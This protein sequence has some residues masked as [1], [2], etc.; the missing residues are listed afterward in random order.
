MDPS[1]S[2][3]EAG[4]SDRYEAPEPDTGATSDQDAADPARH[5]RFHSVDDLSLMRHN[6][7]RDDTA[8]SL[9]VGARYP[10]GDALRARYTSKDAR[11]RRRGE[12]EMVE[13]EEELEYVDDEEEP[14]GYNSRGRS[15]RRGLHA[16]ETLEEKKEQMNALFGIM[17]WKTSITEKALEEHSETVKQLYLEP[18]LS[19]RDYGCSQCPTLPLRLITSLSLLS[20]SLALLIC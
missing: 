19:V 12:T 9:N 6:G 20:R 3:E 2:A 14:V 4:F 7:G 15:G 18:S 1:Y 16:P 8:Q 11:N 13:E 17:P 10:S 5:V